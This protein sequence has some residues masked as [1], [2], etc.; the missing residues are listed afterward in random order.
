MLTFKEIKSQKIPYESLDAETQEYVYDTFK[1]YVVRKQIAD[2]NKELTALFASRYGHN[3]REYARC[4]NEFNSM[5]VHSN[6]IRELDYDEIH[7]DYLRNMSEDRFNYHLSRTGNSFDRKIALICFSMRPSERIANRVDFPVML[8]YANMQTI[9]LE[10]ARQSRK[11][12]LG[13]IFEDAA[14]IVRSDFKAANGYRI[15]DSVVQA[16]RTDYKALGRKAAPVW[17]DMLEFYKK[18]LKDIRAIEAAAFVRENFV[19]TQ[20]EVEEFDRIYK[21]AIGKAHD[22]LVA[23]RQGAEEYMEANPDTYIPADY[24]EVF[25]RAYAEDLYSRVMDGPI[26]SI[27]DAFLEDPIFAPKEKTEKKNGE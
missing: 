11:T 25:S 26:S 6:L 7:T 5:F 17:R 21:F 15:N 27:L 3:P 19:F 23:D 8:A 24:D 10:M 16:E 1:R 4:F 14:K 20:K 2:K 9:V 22:D 18:H 13:T 12:P